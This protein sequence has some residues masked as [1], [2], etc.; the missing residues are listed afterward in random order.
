M[1]RD[2]KD[3]FILQVQDHR[4]NLYGPHGGL[5]IDSGGYINRCLEGMYISVTFTVCAFNYYGNNEECLF[6]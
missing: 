3:M 5:R 4:W 6:N 1:Y 2:R